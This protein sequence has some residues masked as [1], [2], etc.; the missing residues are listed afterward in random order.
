MYFC[1]GR[2]A[3]FDLSKWDALQEQYALSYWE[4]EVFFKELDVVIV[5]SGLVGLSAALSIVERDPALRVAVFERGPLPIGASTRNAGFACFGSMTELLDDLQRMDEDRVWRL[6]NKR[7]QGLQRLRRRLGDRELDF[8]MTGGYELFR[9]E[10][11]DRYQACMEQRAVFNRILADIT[12][13]REVFTSA[14]ERIAE[15]GFRG[16][17]RLVYNRAEGQ[18]HPGKMIARLLTLARARGVQ[19][20]TGMEIQALN[21]EGNAVVLTTTRGWRIVARR[22][23]VATNGFA[24]QLLPATP[25]SPARNQVLL[26]APVPGLSL[27]GVF[28]YD[29]GY[30]YFR[31]VEGR[32]LLG[33]GRHLAETEEQTEE[34][35][36]TPR[37]RTALLR[38]LQDVILPGR[39]VT[40]DHWWSGVLGIGAEKTP[41]VKKVSPRIAVAARL[42]GM[43]VAIGTLV[44][45]EAAGKLENGGTVEGRK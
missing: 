44:G 6:V 25:V 41:I 15:F 31:E 14:D 39:S 26:T 12:G 1:G 22:A 40:I 38:L 37:I 4:Q 11:E 35:G 3:A 9:P 27:R 34:L 21:D 17:R 30:Y 24:R 28:H 10:E 43:G 5:G 33:G 32:L 2:G 16:V 45:E 36:T 18:L 20:L 13:E 42:G 7:W 19:V 23:L 8:G 29:R